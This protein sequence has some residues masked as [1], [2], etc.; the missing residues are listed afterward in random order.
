MIKTCKTCGLDFPPEGFPV[1]KLNA[2]GRRPHCKSCYSKYT[3]G[4]RNAEV[5]AR[6]S[7][8]YNQTE[9]G[10]ATHQRS[11]VKHR[12][13]RNASTRSWRKQ[14]GAQALRER[15]Q[16][17]LYGITQRELG[18]ACAVC[19]TQERLCV[20]HDHKCCRGA[21]SCGKCVRDVL[22]VSCNTLVG[23]IESNPERVAL[24]NGYLALWKS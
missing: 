22:C 5:C 21:K 4:I 1:G 20:D 13:R 16:R 9:K 10:K 23:R 15:T 24:I 2:G 3:Y 11:S 7:K 18:S 12:D 19:G 6:A 17:Q 8:K 14:Q